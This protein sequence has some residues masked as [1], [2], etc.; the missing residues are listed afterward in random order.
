MARMRTT[1]LL[2]LGLAAGVGTAVSCGGA[3]RKESA[4]EPSA[5]GSGDG[6]ARGGEAG[7]GPEEQCCCQRYDERGDASG[8]ARAD[9]STCK[10]TGGTCTEDPSQCEEE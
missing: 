8:A 2:A 10:S 1:L 3:S 7:E 6:A 4:S 9:R 5:A